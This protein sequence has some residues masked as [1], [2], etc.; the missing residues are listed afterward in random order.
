M[1]GM[2]KTMAVLLFFFL[3]WVGG[4]DRKRKDG[5]TLFSMGEGGNKGKWNGSWW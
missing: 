5:G 4:C 1:S 3:R 2:G